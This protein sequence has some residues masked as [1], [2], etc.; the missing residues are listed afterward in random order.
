MDFYFSF[1][2]TPL[3]TASCVYSSITAYNHRCRATLP[4]YQTITHLPHLNHHISSLST[5]SS[6]RVGLRFF[7]NY[8]AAFRNASAPFR[9]QGFQ[10]RRFQSSDAGA[11]SQQQQSTFQRLWNSPVGLKTVHFWCVCKCALDNYFFW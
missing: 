1:L 8:R 4:S 5:M 9:R 6:S 10:G 2:S 11:A 3:V 7:E